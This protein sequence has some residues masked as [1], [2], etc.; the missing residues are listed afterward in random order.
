MAKKVVVLLRRSPLNTVKNSEALRHCVG[1]TMAENRV[2]AILTG[3]AV[4]LALPV[5]PKQVGGG[6]IK[7]HLDFLPRLKARILVD[8]TTMEQ[9]D[10]D[11]GRLPPGIKVISRAE[12][13]AELT[14]A[15]VVIPF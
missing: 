4:W 10:I 14:E 8:R 1:L 2:T 9:Y 15:D 6:E 5:N 3:P 11:Q 13:V 12:L 7:K